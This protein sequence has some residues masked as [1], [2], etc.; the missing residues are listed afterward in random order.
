MREYGAKE[1]RSIQKKSQQ[2]DI[3]W[4]IGVSGAPII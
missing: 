1:Q 2:N 3:C 4:V